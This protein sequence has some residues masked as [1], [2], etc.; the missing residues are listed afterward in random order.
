MRWV[1]KANLP[2][3]PV[4]VC[5]VSAVAA[6]E[7]A[8]LERMGIEVIAVEPS[9]LLAPPV[10][11]HADMLLH[12]LGGER[13]FTAQR[14]TAH[15]RRLEEL[16]FVLLDAG[17]EPQGDYPHDIPLNVAAMGSCAFIGK[18]CPE[19]ELTRYYRKNCR[20][21]TVNQGYVKCSV[22]V[23][24]E[25]AMVTADEGIAA[26]AAAVGMDVLKI[27]SGGIFIEGYDTGFI[28][29]CCGLVARDTLVFCGDVRKLA[30]GERIRA[31]A[32]EHG[33]YIEPLTGGIPRDVG[34]ILPLMEQD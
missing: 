25:Q 9:P 14:N 6:E 11:S 8:A 29:G 30:D 23:I 27:A 22:C 16:G 2:E 4:T 19:S 26:A 24:A 13:L 21:L 28:G 18:R 31:F 20:C 3:N 12:H 32:R 17:A 7:K 33:V 15:C 10:A 1:V 34:G 5:A